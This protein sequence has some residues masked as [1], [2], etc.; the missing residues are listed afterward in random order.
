MNEQGMTTTGDVSNHSRVSDVVPSPEN[1]S[2]VT[3]SAAQR[4]DVLVVTGRFKIIDNA[5]HEQIATANDEESGL[6]IIR[7]LN[8]MKE[9]K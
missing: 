3:P 6:L 9:S 4:Y 7:A 8:A 2:Q 5:T 1:V